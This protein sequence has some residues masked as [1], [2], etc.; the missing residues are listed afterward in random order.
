MTKN[1][2]RL[3]VLAFV[4]VCVLASALFVTDDSA[5][6][7]EVDL[8]PSVLLVDS[9]LGDAD[10]FRLHW[11]GEDVEV[12]N[13]E[14][15]LHLES[16]QLPNWWSEC[17]SV[18]GLYPPA[19]FFL[20]DSA[21]NPITADQI[22]WA[23]DEIA[24]FGSQPK[25]MI[26]STGPSGLQVRRYVQDFADIKQSSRA[27]VVGLMFMGTPHQG[28]SALTYFPQ[29]R[30]WERLADGAG[31]SVEELHQ[32]SDFLSQLNNRPFPNVIKSL[33][34]RGAAEDIGFGTSDGAGVENDL[35]LPTTVSAQIANANVRATISQAIGLSDL[36]EPTTRFL[37]QGY[38]RLD[39]RPIAQLSAIDSYVTAPDSRAALR[40]FYQV[41]FPEEAPVTH[42]STVLTVDISGSMRREIENGLAMLDAAILATNDFLLSVSVRSGKPY[43]VPESI[44]VF[45]FDTE[46]THITSSHDDDARKKVQ[47]IEVGGWTDMGIA[48]EASLDALA[49]S[50]RSADKRIILLSDGLPTVGMSA[51]EI[52]SGPVAAA[53]RD[54]IAIDTIAFGV[55]D[56]SDVAF[57]EEIATVTGGSAHN[58]NDTYDLRLS[59]MSAR[60]SSLGLNLAD[61]SM[62]PAQEDSV[63]IAVVEEGTR[64]I[65]LGIIADGAT[66]DF[67]L[68]HDGNTLDSDVLTVTRGADGMLTVQL[69]VPDPGVYTLKLSGDAQRAHVFAVMQ[70]DLFRPAQTAPLAQDWS[71]EIL[72]IATG[73]FVLLLILTFVLSRRARTKRKLPKHSAPA[74]SSTESDN[75]FTLS[76]TGE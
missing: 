30:V 43:A 36:W 76:S 71:L 2:I 17:D 53:A 22:V 74:H 26:V 72:V 1:P 58:S 38:E 7:A 44:D 50:P 63:E 65:E 16:T 57:L 31:L 47:D 55:E 54:G 6:A 9:S 19:T 67:K 51:E 68:I 34:V 10:L 8:R 41:W 11:L 18:Q 70:K 3:C 27:D 32:E 21:Q 59:F 64:L 42:I 23:L 13:S 5:F 25:T 75:N 35:S 15:T 33:G 29:V 60:F 12:M 40:E 37:D 61:H 20:H 69:D 49:D 28:Y 48:L 46:V 56:Q 4:V 14:D 73:T 24:T 66:P 62:S 52:M 45:T 39:S